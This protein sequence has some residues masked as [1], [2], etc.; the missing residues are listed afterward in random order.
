MCAHLVQTPTPTQ[1]VAVQL[2][3]YIQPYIGHRDEE[4]VDFSIGEV[5]AIP[6]ACCHFCH[7]WALLI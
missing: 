2:H 6:I 4:V 5:T 7:V 1:A 3:G